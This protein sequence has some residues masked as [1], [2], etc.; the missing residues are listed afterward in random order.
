MTVQTLTNLSK[1]N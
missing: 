1:Q